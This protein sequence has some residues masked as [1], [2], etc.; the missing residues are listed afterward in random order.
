M[1]KK[2]TWTKVDILGDN[3]VNKR[4]VVTSSWRSCLDVKTVCEWGTICRRS[5]PLPPA[6]SRPDSGLIVFTV[7]C[8]TQSQL[9][10]DPAPC[11]FNYGAWEKWIGRTCQHSSSSGGPARR[12]LGE[13]LEWTFTGFTRFLNEGGWAS[14]LF[15]PFLFPPQ[16][17][18]GA[19]GVKPPSNSPAGSASFMIGCQPVTRHPCL[20][21]EW[22]SGQLIKSS[23]SWGEPKHL[24]L[25]HAVK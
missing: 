19:A 12:F 6:G 17:E 3:L 10:D 25:F 18:G 22:T 4:L 16:Q 13:T 1:Q 5:A 23:G 15:F 7:T 11:T 24:S 21:N 14:L 2:Q 20:M 9:T 8:R